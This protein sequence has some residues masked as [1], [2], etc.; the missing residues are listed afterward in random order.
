MEVC[1]YPDTLCA[2]IFTLG[3]RF[4]IHLRHEE[5]LL[6]AFT[7][8]YCSE[9]DFCS[10]KNASSCNSRQLPGYFVYCTVER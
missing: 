1:Y 5:N 4:K 8:A 2:L 10:P 6:L 9:F 3:E 7:A